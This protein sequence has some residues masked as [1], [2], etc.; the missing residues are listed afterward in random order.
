M[1]TYEFLQTSFT[2]QYGNQLLGFYITWGTDATD[3]AAV[4]IGVGGDNIKM[5]I[6]LN[7]ATVGLST[8]TGEKLDPATATAHTFDWY[9]AMMNG[10]IY[11]EATPSTYAAM[12]FDFALG[13]LEIDVTD[14]STD[15]LAATWLDA[16]PIDDLYCEDALG[17]TCL[18]DVADGGSTANYV[19]QEAVS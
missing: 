15:T 17:A 18:G 10:D 19:E 2:T 16:G 13:H 6:T 1:S 9:V 8:A 7:L 11:K 5:T 4:D 14:G 12:A 3:T